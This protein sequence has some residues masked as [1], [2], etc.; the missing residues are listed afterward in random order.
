MRETL[1]DSLARQVAVVLT[2]FV[3]RYAVGA[4]LQVAVSVIVVPS[5]GVVLV[6]ATV[7]RGT[8]PAGGTPGP[9]IQLTVTLA[10]APVPALFVPRSAYN[11]VPCKRPTGEQVVADGHCA[12]GVQASG[13]AVEHSSHS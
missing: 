6:A 10:F 3:Q 2:Q 4:L 7:H 1:D 13:V 12:I 9:L 8:S 5:A 11:A